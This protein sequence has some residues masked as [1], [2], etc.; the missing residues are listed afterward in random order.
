MS[1]EFGLSIR[2]VQ[3]LIATGEELQTMLAKSV[4]QRR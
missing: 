4:M 1:P 3:R 2:E